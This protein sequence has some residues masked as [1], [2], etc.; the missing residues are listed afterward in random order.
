[1]YIFDATP[2]GRILN[3]FSKDQETLDK[4]LPEVIDEFLAC[5]L[6]VLSVIAIIIIGTPLF[7]LGISM[8]SPLLSF[9]NLSC[10][11]SVPAI[12]PLC[13]LYYNIQQYYRCSSRELRRLD[14]VSRSP[15]FSHFAETLAGVASIRAYG[16]QDRFQLTNAEKQVNFLPHSDKQVDVESRAGYQPESIPKQHRGEPV[17]RDAT[18]ILRDADRVFHGTVRYPDAF[19]GIRGS[20]RSAF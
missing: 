17:G 7:V 11:S 13:Y 10:L 14:S 8:L 2:I 19:L 6:Y 4:D 18:R 15:I 16:A 12:I 20:H 5:F 3:R 1:L 9:S